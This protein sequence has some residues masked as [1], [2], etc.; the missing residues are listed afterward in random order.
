MLVGLENDLDISNHRSRHL[1]RV[2]VEQANIIFTMS[3]SH[4]E[5][6]KKLGG[7]GRVYLLGDYAGLKR[8][9][10]EIVDPYGQ[11]LDVYRYTFERMK[12]LLET[13]AAKLLKERD[14]EDRGD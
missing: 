7:D 10:A 3:R 4:T 12:S 9:K 6:V 13:A 14:A 11:E 8:S 5:R 2:L 1:S